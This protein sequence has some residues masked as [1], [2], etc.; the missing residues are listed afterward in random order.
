M[1]IDT[2]NQDIA[3]NLDDC[4]FDQKETGDM[5]HECKTTLSGLF[6]KHAPIVTKSLRPNTEW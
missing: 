4:S 6:E 3:D 2:L 1:D 5:L